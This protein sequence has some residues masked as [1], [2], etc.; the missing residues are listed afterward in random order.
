MPM[1]DRQYQ[2]IDEYIA[3][4]PVELQSTL[5]RIRAV[6]HETAPQA[7]EAISYGMPT[8]KLEGNVV[9]FAVFK[10]HY[11]F[12]PAASG[13]EHFQDKLA[14]YTTSKGTIQFPL[15]QPVPYDLIREITA[16]RV[17]ENLQRAEAKK[18]KK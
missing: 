1:S 15:D 9:H 3:G 14:A 5:Q 16:Y 2:N 7:S 13:V 18:N 11:G 6:I 12:F 10:D 4:C 8:F 17:T